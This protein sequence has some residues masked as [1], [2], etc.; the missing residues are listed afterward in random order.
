[1]RVRCETKN[2]VECE[3][4]YV[5][6]NTCTS[7]AVE[8]RGDGKADHVAPALLRL[9]ASK[10]KIRIAKHTCHLSTRAWHLLEPLDH[11]CNIRTPPCLYKQCWTPFRQNTTCFNVQR[12]QTW[13]IVVTSVVLKTFER[14]VRWS[15]MICVRR[16]ILVPADRGSECTW[17]GIR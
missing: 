10:I 6:I 7:R 9:S 4:T 14:I 1:M 17:S 12:H 13:G 16:G 3:L 5:I 11:R 2:E 15:L 8:L